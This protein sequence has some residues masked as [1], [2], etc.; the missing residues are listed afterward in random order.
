MGLWSRL[1]GP[2]D[3]D[4]FARAMARALRAAGTADG[5]DYDAGDYKLTLRGSGDHHVL[6]LSNA[7]AE[8][9]GAAR[10]DRN[11]V[12][13]KYVALGQS[14]LSAGD[15]DGDETFDAARPMLLPRIQSRFYHENIRL[16]VA[17][18]P[19]PTSADA[20]ATPPREDA[21]EHR[22]FTDHLLLDLVI[23][24]PHA[25]KP[26][27]AMA[28]ER[29]GVTFDA[30]L[31]IAR[32]NLWSRSNEAWEEIATGVHVSPWHDTHDP[33][34][35]FLHDLIWQLPVK[36]QHVAIAP[37]RILLAVSGDHDEAGLVVLATVAEQVMDVDR[38][39]SCVA[40]R[41]T[42]TRW[43]P[44]LPPPGH[45][46]HWPLRK[47]KVR[48]EARDYAEQKEMLS[49]ALERRGD[50]VFVASFS[51]IE[52]KDGGEWLTWAAW[53]DNVTDML[54]PHPDWFAL[55]GGNRPILW[56]RTERALQV[57][58]ALIAKTEHYPTRYRI[59]SFP[60][61][62]QIRAMNPVDEPTP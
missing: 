48:S 42:G 6:F 4:A 57:A 55:G 61:E 56:V 21:F 51:V 13:Q 53:P 41:L 36:G 35:L 44:W 27:T 60:S 5:I 7:Y 26:V 31:A 40:H 16:A 8:Y 1:F 2:P 22:P 32:D 37:N 3:R 10:R 25:I 12:V 50:D 62:E 14:L 24:L 18:L 58:G 59:R 17:D 46:A 28:F 19:R 9:A 33:S 23:D 34:R 11:A 54:L 15:G 20:T 52:A 43:I 38:P 45:P 47:L 49:K 39:V 29:W 30:A